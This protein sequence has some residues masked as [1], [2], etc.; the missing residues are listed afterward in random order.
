MTLYM[1]KIKF[2]NIFVF[3]QKISGNIFFIWFFDFCGARMINLN[4]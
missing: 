1:N 3:G 2:A 4:N